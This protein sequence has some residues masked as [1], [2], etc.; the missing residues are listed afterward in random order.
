MHSE[1]LNSKYNKTH[2]KWT[3]LVNTYGLFKKQTR[4]VEVY[5]YIQAS[6]GF[7]VYKWN[8]KWVEFD[9]R[10]ILKKKIWIIKIIGNTANREPGYTSTE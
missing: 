1:F 10:K 7:R 4:K 8:F 9:G 5:L 3:V 2:S 6:Y